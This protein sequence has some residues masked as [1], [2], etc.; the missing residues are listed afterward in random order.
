M[1]HIQKNE[2]PQ[3]I[4]VW[5]RKFKNVHGRWPKYDDIDQDLPHKMVLK[6]GLVE[7]QGSICC[8]CCKRIVRENSHIEHFRPK[9][10]PRYVK[11]SLEYDNLLAS[12][13]G[14]NNAKENCGHRKG[15][16]FDEKLMISPLEKDCEDNFKYSSRGKIMAVD[17]NVRAKYTIEALKLDSPQL[18]AAREMAMWESGA[19]EVT[20]EEECRELLERFRKKDENGRY[21]GF[22][23]VVVYQLEKRLAHFDCVK[24]T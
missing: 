23:D 9:G 12:C 16:E 6:E 1:Q 8:Y 21:V 22:C 10:N 18:N 13:Q 20:S 24:D 3:E 17:G 7:E 2:E 15:N 5:K 11:L 4:A 19:M 14:Y